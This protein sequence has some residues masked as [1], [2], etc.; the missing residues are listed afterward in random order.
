MA[1]EEWILETPDGSEYVIEPDDWSLDRYYDEGTIRA[2]EAELQIPRRVPALEKQWIRYVDGGATRFL[3][4]ISRKPAISGLTKKTIKATGAEALLMNCPCPVISIP[5]DSV[6]MQD[7][8]S[9]AAYPGLIYAANSHIP[10]GWLEDTLP[11]ETTDD[12]IAH[13]PGVVTDATNGIVKFANCGT[14]S[15]IGN[16]TICVSGIDYT[17]RASYAIMAA[18][19]RSTYRD[20]DDLY[21][22]FYYSSA[23]EMGYKFLPLYALNA[24]D[25]RCRTGMVESTYAF[26]TPIALGPE[27]MVGQIL[28]GVATVHGLNLRP[29]YA[30]KYC[31]IDALGDFEDTDGIFEIHEDE[32]DEVNFREPSYSPADSLTGLGACPRLFQQMQS[33]V[34]TRPGCAFVR[35]QQEFLEAY[36]DDGGNL[37]PLTTAHWS[38]T[39][40]KNVME[41]T[42]P[43][44]KYIPPGSSIRPIIV[45]MTANTYQLSGISLRAG[46][47]AV[48][49]LGARSLDIL[50]AMDAIGG[51]V[52]TYAEDILPDLY[53]SGSLSGTLT[54]GA[55][56]KSEVSYT[57]AAFS[58]PSFSAV[59][60]YNPRVLADITL[61]AS[62]T[63]TVKPY[64][65]T[66]KFKVS[67]NTSTSFGSSNVV[68]EASSQHYIVEKDT[69]TALD[70]TRK[71]TWGTTN[72]LNISVVLLGAL[73]S[74]SDNSNLRVSVKIYVVGRRM[75]E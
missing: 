7:L 57:S 64:S 74:A 53:N 60:D 23:L 41:L 6:D 22:H 75:L 68:Q 70:I 71:V 56:N 62:S 55:T 50:D 8:F 58:L 16:K 14:R 63:G 37:C 42:T 47:A 43:G 54:V 29:R 13:G 73:P 34:S 30:G 31:Y 33:I 69:L 66:A 35:G 18:N 36:F 67:V 61:S 11:A 45:G 44:H 32:C 1:S 21:A 24:F 59:S 49:Q 4:Y 3:G 38:A 52:N 26:P 15:R 65:S 9:D 51:T 27:D 48:L 28:A 10:S 46:K 72:Y 39:L 20:E 25:T 2:S 19:D 5:Y 12:W 40:P 17:D